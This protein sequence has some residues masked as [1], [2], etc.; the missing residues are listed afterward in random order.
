VEYYGADHVLYGSDYPCWNPAAALELFDEIGLSA[1][2][3]DKILN[4]NARRFFGL[5]S[6]AQPDPA[7]LLV[8]AS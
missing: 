1:A 3:Q 4:S 2:D 7:T 6:A 5:P 8:E